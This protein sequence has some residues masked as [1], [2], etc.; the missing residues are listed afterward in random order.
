[1]NQKRIQIDEETKR[2]LS[3]HNKI[4]REIELKGTKYY[5]QEFISS[6]YKAVVW[7]GVDE[8]GHQVA[9]KFTIYEDYI[10]RSYLEEVTRAAKLK[11]YPQFASFYD[12]GLIEIPFDEGKKKFVCFIEEWV[13]G[14]TLEKFIQEKEITP[15]FIKSYVAQMCEVLNILKSL[16]LR[17]DDLHLKNIIVANPLKGELKKDYRIKIIDMG[18]LKLYDDPLTKPKDDFGNFVDHLIILHNA[19]LF[20]LNHKRKPLCS[21]QKRFLKEMK[22]LLTL[23]IEEDP[24]RA[25]TDPEKIISQFEHAYTR[26]LF[27]YKETE[28]KLEDPFDY[29][30]AE[31]ISSDKLLVELFADTTPWI[32]EVTSPNPIL[33]TGPRGCGKSTI[34]RR[35]SLKALLNRPVEEIKN[36]Q[37]AGFYISCSAD[38][39]NR[40]G[41]ITSEKVVEKFQKEIIHYF[42]LLLCREICQTF[43]NISQRDDREALFGFGEIQEKELFDFL[44]EKLNKKDQAT[45]LQGISPI[46]HLLNIIESEM[47][48]C[49]EQFLRGYNLEFTTPIPF[50]TELTSFLT[51]KIPYFKG[52]KI[53]F[54]IDDFSVHRVSEPVQQIL[55]PIIWDRQ[56]THIFKLSAEKYGIAILYE[57]SAESVPTADLT[58][59]FREID[60][61]RY[62]IDLSDKGRREELIK[63]ARELLDRRLQLAEYNGTCE[64]IIGHSEYPEGSIGKAL[65]QSEK[66]KRKDYYHGLETIAEICSGD[67]S[68]LLEIYRRIFA[69]SGVDKSTKEMVKKYIQHK[70]IVSVSRNFLEKIK[71]FYPMGK[72]MYDI[73]E[74]FG[75]LCRKILVFGKEMEYKESNGSIKYVPP[76]TSRIEVHQTIGKPEEEFDDKQEKL[77]K[78]LIRRAVFIEM[79]PG[80]ARATSGLTLRWQLRRIYCPAFYISPIKTVAIK[81]STSDFKFFLI[82]P[83]EKCEAEFKKWEKP[84]KTEST[85]PL[86][87]EL[88]EDDKNEED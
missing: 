46:E 70:A 79:E 66:T 18:S 72:E 38:L 88:E 69:E 41:C 87:P 57:S 17:H 9:I 77:M 82:N 12:A 63:F 32:K 30:S 47:N 44:V 85:W 53:T 37:I 15:S 3:H 21:S 50:I 16:N 1:M 29:I 59:E 31:H 84:S 55:N 42:N 27:P 54:L 11:S 67:I 60:C 24:Q 64:E 22:I 62:Y 49:Y 8:Y 33:L 26:S 76:E 68:A 13:D 28:L 43:F 78:E 56:P 74:S 14:L 52:K 73:V 23:M 80:R 75:T 65:A 2:L 83:K 35:F 58:R 34:F 10:N 86:F 48:Y 7:K 61:G 19:M 36:S 20:D 5:P 39:R 81:W 4:P 40:F 45:K 25:L 51:D 6:G 71:A